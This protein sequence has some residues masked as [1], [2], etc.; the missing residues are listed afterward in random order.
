[1]RTLAF[2]S[3]SVRRC[4]AGTA[5]FGSRNSADP[6]RGQQVQLGKQ[7]ARDI[8][9]RRRCFPTRPAVQTL[10]RVARRILSTSTTRARSPQGYSFDIVDSKIQRLA[11]LPGGETFFYTGLTDRIKTETSWRRS[12]GTRIVDSRAQEG[13]QGLRIT[14]PNWPGNHLLTLGALIFFIR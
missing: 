9:H 1:M 7:A 12:W 2:R 8:H 5:A 11:S 14:R 10:R 3:P 6:A 4:V 13:G